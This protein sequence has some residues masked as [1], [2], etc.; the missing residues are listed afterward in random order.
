MR[1]KTASDT[2][3][4]EREE[5]FMR[6]TIQGSTAKRRMNVMSQAALGRMVLPCV[7]VAWG[8]LCS[9]SAYGAPKRAMSPAD[10]LGIHGVSSPVISPDGREVLYTV[11]SWKSTS[12]DPK[13][14][15]KQK[16]VE[17]V[18]MAPTASGSNEKPRQIT[19]GAN[20][21]SSPAWSSDGKLISFLTDRGNYDSDNKNGDKR[22]IWVM[23]AEGGEAWQLT[24][25]KESVGSSLWSP[26]GDEIAYTA[27]LPDAKDVEEAHERGDNAQV[28]ETN[29][30]SLGLYV[31]NVAGKSTTYLTPGR[32]FTIEGAPTWSPDGKQ[33]AFGAKPTPMIRD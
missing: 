15:G 11:G 29:F 10:V 4:L 31:F 1:V 21:E 32:T 24:D 12:T 26:A 20:G 3:S 9:T 17:H 13:K 7:A 25:N 14:P 19:F 6:S 27:K 8:L 23:H 16:E 2:A 30:P 5:N 28:Y 18:W 22:Q 33:I